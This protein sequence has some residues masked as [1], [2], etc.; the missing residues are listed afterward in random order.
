MTTEIMLPSEETKRISKCEAWATELVVSTP[1]QH[2]KARSDVKSIKLLKNGIVKFFEKS[3]DLAYASWKE[4]CGQ[5]KGFTDKLDAAERIAKDKI[6]RYEIAEEE[7]RLAM[8]RKLQA[9]A[10]EKARK[11]TER[12]AARAA[13]AEASGKLE[14]AEALA[15][16]AEAVVPVAIKVE[17]KLD[18]KGSSIKTTWKGEVVSLMEL[19][20]AAVPGSVAAS[21]LMVNQKMVDAFARSTKGQVTVPGIKFVEEKSMSM[22]T[23]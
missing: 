16:Q 7:K 2:S 5:E 21:F 13:K 14:K 3:K 17:S 18:T 23:K 22:S 1:E 12:L 6:M 11:E 4:I 9:E 19:T 8:E 20:A 10:D 15:E